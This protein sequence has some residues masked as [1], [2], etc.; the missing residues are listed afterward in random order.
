MFFVIY[1]PYFNFKIGKRNFQIES[2]FFGV[3]IGATVLFAIRVVSW[4]DL[5]IGLRGSSGLSPLGILILFLSMVFISIFLDQTGF[6]EYCANLA[7][8]YSKG[9]TKRLF[10]VIYI[11][12][13]ILTIFTSNDDDI[14]IF[15]PFIYYLAKNAKINPIPYLFAEF[16]AA[17]TSSMMLYTGN[18]TNII[19]AGA[20]KIDFSSYT[21]YMFLP[22][23]V[24]G[25]ITVSILYLIFRKDINRKVNFSY[26]VDFSKIIKDKTGTF[27]GLIVLI[28]CIILLS[29]ASKL[30]LEMWIIALAC[31]LIL[32]LFI[33]I[34]KII[35]Y[36]FY[37]ESR[38]HIP[39]I[40]KILSKLPWAI[41]PF[42][43]SLFLLINA[44]NI[45]GVITKIGIF[46]TSI[47]AGN[48]FLTVIVYGFGSALS[49]NFLNNIPMTVAF[50]PLIVQAGS[51]SFAAAL[52][53]ALGSNLAANITPFGALAGIMWLSIL[54]SKG[55]IIRIIDFIKW[56]ALVTFFA[57]GAAL[58]V[59]GLELILF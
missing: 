2:Y 34:R 38:V 11:T 56:G 28:G 48:E 24:A 50:V 4:N 42:I 14:I 52:A 21:Y 54:K 58:I 6:F 15:T 35:I 29:F 40:T 16:F 9:D 44:L 27:V 23:I 19:V 5:V 53:T 36:L 55:I 13:F 26:K 7:L 49:A 30:G 33:L 32:M 47:T 37:K 20:L 41:I 45:Y 1:H 39:N 17:N 57:L 43:L 25:I 8:K 51:N 10:F 46:L 18:P 12:V 3:L 31:A 59:L 22:T